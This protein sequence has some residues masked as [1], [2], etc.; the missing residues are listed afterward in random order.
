MSGT[1]FISHFD[2]DQFARDVQRAV[3]DGLKGGYEIEHLGFTSTDSDGSLVHAVL[4]IWRKREETRGG[5]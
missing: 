5:K 3:E 1:T 4:I 2:G